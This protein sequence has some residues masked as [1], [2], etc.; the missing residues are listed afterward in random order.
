M[1]PYERLRQCRWGLG[2]GFAL[3]LGMIV[4]GGVVAGGPAEETALGGSLARSGWLLLIGC[5]IG[6]TV[7]TAAEA[8]V[9]ELRGEPPEKDTPEPQYTTLSPP[10]SE[11]GRHYSTLGPPAEEPP[12]PD[13]PPADG[14]RKPPKLR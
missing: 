14:T 3:A 6:L 13:V 8:I 7:C 11:P 1:E 5:M 9:L 12:E 10:P 2:G 4:L